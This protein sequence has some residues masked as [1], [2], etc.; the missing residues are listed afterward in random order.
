MSVYSMY[1]LRFS[2]LSAEFNDC[3][4]TASLSALR[5][6]ATNFIRWIWWRGGGGYD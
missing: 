1:L 3:S 5:A 6:A 4:A 2:A